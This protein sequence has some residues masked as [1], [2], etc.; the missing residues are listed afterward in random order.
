[1]D[2][3]DF[4]TPNSISHEDWL[5]D[6]LRIPS[7]SLPASPGD[8]TLTNFMLQLSTPL[9]DLHFALRTALLSLFVDERGECVFMCVR[10]C[11]CV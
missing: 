8:P 6:T 3:L 10:I 9:H 4:S 2:E 11:E 1:M 5:V 7:T